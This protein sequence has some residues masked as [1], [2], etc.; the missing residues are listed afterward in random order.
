MTIATD[1]GAQPAEP[2]SGD[3]RV[4]GGVVASPAR[5]VAGWIIMGVAIQVW[6]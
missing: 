5:I 4:L 1:S 6:P 3:N 2:V